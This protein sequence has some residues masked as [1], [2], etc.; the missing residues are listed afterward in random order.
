MKV[1]DQR[2][3]SICE[4]RKVTLVEWR[5]GEPLEHDVL[6]SKLMAVEIYLNEGNQ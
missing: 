4:R 6:V 1:R 5:D 2:K 3:K